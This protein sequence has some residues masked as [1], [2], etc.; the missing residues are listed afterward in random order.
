MNVVAALSMFLQSNRKS[1]PVSRKS[2]TPNSKASLNGMTHAYG[3]GN[4]GER[5]AA[6][7]ADLP[8]REELLLKRAMPADRIPEVPEWRP[9]D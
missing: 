2:V 3:D 8:N 1:S 4:A 6:V 5:I 7:L 9:E